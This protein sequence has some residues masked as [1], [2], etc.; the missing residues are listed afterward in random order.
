LV[1]GS[2]MLIYIC[3]KINII[4]A[5]TILHQIVHQE[6]TTNALDALKRDLLIIVHRAMI[7]NII[8]AQNIILVNPDVVNI[9]VRISVK[10]IVKVI[11]NVIVNVNVNMIVNVLTKTAKNINVK[12]KKPL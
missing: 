1:L 7:M 3:Q 12:K 2:S 6:R 8:D 10:V 11:V 9:N 4:L 5:A